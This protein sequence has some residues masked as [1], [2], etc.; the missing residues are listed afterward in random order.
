MFALQRQQAAGKSDAAQAQDT[1]WARFTALADACRNHAIHNPGMNRQGRALKRQ[2]D[3]VL[4]RDVETIIERLLGEANRSIP[5]GPR[6]FQFRLVAIYCDRHRDRMSP[7]HL[8]AFR[9]AWGKLAKG[10]TLKIN[11]PRR[12]QKGAD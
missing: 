7:N 4:A 10:P 3:H 8:A 11:R 9:D 6:L 1:A 12:R 5:I 2:L